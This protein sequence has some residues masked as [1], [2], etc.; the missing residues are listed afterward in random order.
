MGLSFRTNGQSITGSQLGRAELQH[1]AATRRS[2][3]DPDCQ[4][5]IVCGGMQR[6]DSSKTGKTDVSSEIPK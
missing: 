4:G 2:V 1:V 5:Q 3:V 6:A